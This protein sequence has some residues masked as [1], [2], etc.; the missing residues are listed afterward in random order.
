MSF[1]QRQ[2]KIIEC[3]KEFDPK[4]SDVFKGGIEVLATN[5]SDKIAQSA[6]SLRESIYLLA[7][8][9]EIKKSGK[10][11]TMS[12]GKTRKQDLIKNLDP[13]KGAPENIYLL[14]DELT[15]DYLSYFATFAHHADFSDERKFRKKVCEFEIL[16][17]KIFRPHFEVIHDINKFLKIKKP[18]RQDF[19]ELKILMSKNSS[20][21]NHFFQ[22]ASSVWLSYLLKDGYF[23]NSS[24]ITEINGDRKFVIW[25]PAAYLLKSASTEPNKVSKIILGIQ[26]PKKPDERN[27]RL[28]EFFVMTA[29]EM[30]SQYGKL[31]VKRISK[32]CW[33]KTPYP[34]YLDIPISQLMKKLADAN[35]EHP[36]QLLAYALLDVK[37]GESY[38]TGGLIDDYKK[39]QDVK[40]I[41]DSFRYGEIIKKEIPYVFEKFPKSIT[42]L[43]VCLVKKMIYLE[44]CG[45]GDK[46]SKTDASIAWRS[47]IEDHIQ[48]W[49]Y[50][51]RSQLLGK[52][53]NLLISLGQKSIRMLKQVMKNISEIN[54]PA[55]RRLEL[56]VYWTFPKQ[57]YKEINFVIEHNFNN[58]ELHHEYFHLLQNVF[59]ITSK[60]SRK[61]YLSFIEKGPDKKH[62]EFWELNKEQS[63]K[64][65]VDLKI[66]LWK[67]DK[68]KPVLKH[69]SK[70]EKKRFIDLI[71]EKRGFPH[72]DFHVYSSGIVTSQPVS[73][74]NDNLTLEQVF[75]FIKNYKTK[76]LDF[77]AYDGTPKKFQDYVQNDS[78]K[79]SKS[80]LLCFELDSIFIYRFF[81]GIKN[82]VKQ[83][84][85]VV[86]ESVL[87]LC[88]K[89]IDSIKKNEFSELKKMCILNSM[90]MA[91]EDGMGYCSIDFNLRDRVW[92]LL[93]NLIILAEVD[94]SLE[95]RYSQEDCNVIGI[96]INTIDGN[97]FHAIIKYMVWC[98]NHLHQKCIF[99][100]EVKELL[101]NYLE[102]K[103][104]VSISR[105]A[106]L[107]YHL[108]TLYY[109]DTEWIRSKL[110]NLF[111]NKNTNFSKAAWDGHLTNEIHN[112]IFQDL[113][114]HYYTHVK[115]LNSPPLKDDSLWGY[116]KQVI[117]HI[118]L[119]YLLKFKNSTK[120]FYHMINN[121]HEKVL[122]HCAWYI[123]RILHDQKEKPNKSFDTNAFKKLWKNSK[124]TS[125]EELR[126]WVEYSPFNKKETLE[127]L[128]NSLKE[129][130][131]SIRLLSF[132]VNELEPYAKTHAQ[133]TLKCLDILVHKRANNPE[134]YVA[135]DKLKSLL[136]ILLKNKKT[137]QK[138]ISLINYLGELGHNEY[139]ELL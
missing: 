66:R 128:Y 15:K 42:L 102:Q 122:S 3:L 17:E 116:D 31:I 138:T 48:N 120:L 39:I 40:S 111:K 73:E 135:R 139:S 96:S 8:L 87:S 36:T 9:D 100:P 71:K 61:K 115:K 93:D 88:E 132:L 127:L 107:G 28:L 25:S 24:H 10:V 21:Y 78:E 118:T 60:K 98:R 18:T 62:L 129:S 109:Y 32:E 34:N 47:A 38:V 119:A 43:L 53:G 84:N 14:Y 103:I 1:T 30:P 26:I 113:H 110:D 41:I 52:L 6:H 81:D 105:Q 91:L 70:D 131:E 95:D 20:A 83:K 125:N 5:S 69:L 57:F 94:S 56:Y 23:K 33:I 29:I 75:D 117:S 65:Y 137:R 37:L 64:D 92:H 126:M 85:I 114:E 2:S 108:R 76:A 130:T 19:N 77:G 12:K 13:L 22:N 46:K 54:Y 67:A 4:I 112:V 63:G 82:A 35:L 101:S 50:D 44:N 90:V 51:F 74:L 133:L 86:W 99:V 58:Y 7:R 45:K 104:T 124:L 106:V 68:L 97:T 79:Y 59:G 80:S 121:G 123:G 134:F 136:K 55:F 11:K 89:I 16:L 49:Q 27:P 72:P